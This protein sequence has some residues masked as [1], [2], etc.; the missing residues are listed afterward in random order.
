MWLLRS[1]DVDLLDSLF[2][3][4][5]G[6]NRGAFAPGRINLIGEHTD[7]NGFPVLPFALPLGVAVVARPR[8]D[9][10]LVVQNRDTARF[11]HETLALGDLPTRPRRGTWVDYVVAGLRLF[12]PASGAELLVAGDLPIASGLSSSSALVC[13][14]ALLFAPE[15]TD[16]RELAE[17]AR[18][19]EQ[20][21][22]TL[23]GGMDQAVSLLAVPPHALRIDFRPL[24]VEPIPLPAD[25]AVVV[26]D[27]G[28]RAEKGGMAQQ[29]YNDRVR[30][31]GAAAAALG[32]PPG[33][34]L[35]DVPGADRLARART[36]ADPLLARR[37]AFVF[38]EAAR[39]E[40]AVAA[41]QAGDLI[42]LGRLLDHSHAGLRDDYEVSHPQVDALVSA[43]RSHGA[44][45]ARIVG[46][47]FGGCCIALTT[48]SAAEQL[49]TALRQS[50]ATQ[51]FVAVAGPGASTRRRVPPDAARR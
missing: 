46:A 41:L 19:G 33:G 2:A 44:L 36:L 23:S 34:L 11:P 49:A 5:P 9:D 3:A 35:A 50:G 6:S 16:R 24:R 8:H 15:R 40:A 26:A 28:V 29:G 45:G 27:S 51:A 25:F 14:S 10:R 37:A 38:A 32:A 20:Y 17:R 22:G 47:G 13:A 42:T 43:S 4:H 30:Q 7:Y 48:R 39:V 12:P 1:T 31:C 18:L 21:V